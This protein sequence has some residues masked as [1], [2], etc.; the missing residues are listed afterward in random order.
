MKTCA[1]IYNPN[2]GKVLKQKYIKEY[3]SILKKN[4]YNVSVYGTKYHG[5]AKEIVNHLA[6]IDLIIS[7]GGDGTFNE[8]MTGNLNREKRIILAHIPVGTTNDIGVMF[9]YG[10]NIKQNLKDLLNGVIKGMDVCIINGQPF[11]YVAGFGKFMQIPYDTPR[12]LKKKI[13]YFAYLTE[14]IKDFLKPTKLYKIKYKVNG[15][16]KEGYYS[17]MLIS[18]AN[19]IAG[20]NNFYKDIKLDDNK[21]EV[22]FCNFRRRIDIIRTFSILLTTDVQKVSGFEFYRTN[23]IE[24]KFEDYP[25][26]AWCIDGEKLD[27]STLKYEI[28]NERNVQIMLP[29]KNINKIFIK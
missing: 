5:H 24:V 14:G 18:N 9:G 13:G 2:S 16:E 21:F 11:V 26:K 6:N 29:Q 7:M 10:K 12:V 28:K 8:I 3:V 22:L 1:L 23:Y 27:R 4:D 25:K 15:I 19:R 17:F 20:I